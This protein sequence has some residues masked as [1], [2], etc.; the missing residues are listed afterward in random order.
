MELEKRK[1]PIGVFEKPSVITA[2]QLKE[3]IKD[4]AQFPYILKATVAPL[5]AEQLQLT[6][7]EGGWTIQ[8]IIHHC[9]DSH[10][11]AII[12]FKLSL[13]EDQPVIKPYPESLCAELPDSK[14]FPIA[15]SL[16]ILEGVHS[17]WHALLQEMKALDFNRTYIHPEYGKSFRLDEATG[18]Y[19]WHCK[20]HLA[21][22]QLALK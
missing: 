18:N 21:H 6:Y 8:Q 20:H 16:S 15:A 17:R 5:T 2:Q 12:R 7:R 13:T 14:N 3:W 19:S 22:I 9:A 4:I 1:Y 10:M 11:N